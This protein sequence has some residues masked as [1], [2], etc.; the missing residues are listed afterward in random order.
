[1]VHVIHADHGVALA[2]EHL[3]YISTNKSGCSGY[4]I[5]CHWIIIVPTAGVPLPLPVFYRPTTFG[6]SRLAEPS[7]LRVS[8]IKLA[9]SIIFG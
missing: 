2:E 5:V 3:H 7:A 4:D 9:A 6:L 8:T 1:V